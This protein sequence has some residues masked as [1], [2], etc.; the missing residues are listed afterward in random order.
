MDRDGVAEAFELGDGSAALTVGVDLVAEMVSAEV[1][2]RRLVSK[3][4]QI[5][6]SRV[7]AVAVWARLPPRRAGMRRNW[8]LR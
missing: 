3:E 5:T 1:V 8:A 4:C 2:V 6:V 7:W